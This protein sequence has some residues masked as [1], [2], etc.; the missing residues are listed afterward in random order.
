MPKKIDYTA[1]GTELDE[2]LARLQ[3]ADLDVDEAVKA[4]E[5][6]M[7]I[8]EDLEA[9]LKTAENKVTKIRETWEARSKTV[10]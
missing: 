4:Y 10:Q 9:Y 5:R 2:I 7:A 6:G 1:L 3:S 8:V